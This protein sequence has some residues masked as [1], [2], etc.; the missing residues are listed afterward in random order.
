MNSHNADDRAFVSAARRYESL[1]FFSCMNPRMRRA[2]RQ[3]ISDIAKQ[4]SDGIAMR[5][6]NAERRPGLLNEDKDAKSRTWRRNS[7]CLERL[8]SRTR[9]TG[10]MPRGAQGPP[11]WGYLSNVLESKCLIYG[12]LP[13]RPSTSLNCPRRG[14]YHVCGAGTRPEARVDVPVVQRCGGAGGAGAGPP[15]LSHLWTGR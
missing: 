14:A 2:C 7:P 9:G 1:M 5:R 10:E 3:S 12:N 13:G 11:G 6:S 8:V 4:G 15:S